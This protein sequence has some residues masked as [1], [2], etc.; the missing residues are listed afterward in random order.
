[1]RV[2]WNEVFKMSAI[3]FLNIICY[4]IDKAEDQRRQIKKWQKE[5]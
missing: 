5:N 1:M 4:C 3:E 2:S